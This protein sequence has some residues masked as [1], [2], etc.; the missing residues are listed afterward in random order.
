MIWWDD[1]VQGE[2]VFEPKDYDKIATLLKPSGGGGTRL[3]CVAE[4]MKEMK[5]KPVATVILT[6]GMIASEYDL[7]DGPVLFGVVDN[8]GFVPRRGKKI[9]I[10]SLRM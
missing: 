1:G 5:L 2:Q 7:P 9:D 6:D 10:N 3:S 8:P 4:Y